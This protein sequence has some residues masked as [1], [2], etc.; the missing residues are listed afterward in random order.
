M[1]L[2]RLLVAAFLLMA[3][4]AAA[5][6]AEPPLLGSNGHGRV[7][8]L[9]PDLKI[10]PGTPALPKKT[11][12]TVLS[13][14]G[15]RFAS[16]SFYGPRLTIRGTRTFRA[17]KTLPI[18]VGADVYWPERNHVMTVD[19]LP[20]A[21]RRNVIRAFDVRRGTSRTVRL[22]DLLVE[23]QRVGRF[24]RVVTVGG[25][26]LCCSDGRF[27]VTDIS[28]SGVVTRRWRVPLPDGFVR[29]DDGDELIGMH[30]SG[31]LLLASQNERH[32]LIKVHS[33]ETK[34]LPR[35]PEGYYHWLDRRLITD[36]RHVARVDRHAKTVT[37]LVDT[38]LE[39]DAT[40]FDGGFIIG[41]GRAR[42]DANLQRVAENTAPAHVQGYFPVLAHGRLYDLVIDC[43]DADRTAAAIADA[44]TGAAVGE[45]RGRWKLGVLGGGRFDQPFFD[46]VCD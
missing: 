27:V 25:L 40:L 37:A 26:D 43:D 44:T 32:A 8:V 41:F 10:V 45:R 7:R 38:G 19:Y 3:T 33:G 14:D 15:R 5:S 13:P 1:T 46:D 17:I 23:A 16:W 2:T 20:G 30:L 4:P 39:G 35:L 42:Y 24:L 36:S 21:K 34:S 29:S 28:A 9:D 22:G 6:A 31:T 11:D 12:A 18:P